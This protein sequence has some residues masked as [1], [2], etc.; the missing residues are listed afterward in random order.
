MENKITKERVIDGT[1][2]S[3]FKEFFEL[4]YLLLDESGT[5][6]PEATLENLQSLMESQKNYYVLLVW[7]NADLSRITFDEE[8]ALNYIK[9]HPDRGDLYDMSLYDA[10]IEILRR[11]DLGYHCEVNE[12]D[13]LRMADYSFDCASMS[14]TYQVDIITEKDFDDVLYIYRDNPEYFEQLGIEPSYETIRHDMAK[15]PQGC[16]ISNKYFVIFRDPDPVAVADVYL[17]YP[18]QDAIW[19]DLIMISKDLRGLSF[20]SEILR[21]ILDS[22]ARCGFMWAE[23]GFIKGNR[24][25]EKFFHRN[26]FV[27][28]LTETSEED[29][30]VYHHM[31][32]G[33]Q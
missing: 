6:A 7:E 15:C 17:H 4:M 20:G 12:V 32:R 30:T 8:A 27:D 5:P 33:L 31:I 22:F 18:R 13:G 29:G 24:A 26:W 3:N 9:A 16:D 10:I 23:A 19:L 11:K 21:D 25:A 1:F 28:L 2:F 14:D